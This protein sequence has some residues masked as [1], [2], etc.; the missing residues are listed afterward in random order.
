MPGENTP[1]GGNWST[2][3]GHLLTVKQLADELGKDYVHIMQGVGGDAPGSDWLL[4]VHA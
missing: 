1:F 4:A 2:W 3:I